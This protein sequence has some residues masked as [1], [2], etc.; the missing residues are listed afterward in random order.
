MRQHPGSY[1]IFLPP[2]HFPLHFHCPDLFHA[3]ATVHCCVCHG[4][5]YHFRKAR[6]VY[7]QTPNRIEFELQTRVLAD[8]TGTTRLRITVSPRRVMTRVVP[9]CGV[10]HPKNR[11]AD[12]RE[13]VTITGIRFMTS[14]PP[15]LRWNC[16]LRDLRTR[17]RRSDSPSGYGAATSC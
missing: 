14:R 8:T 11:V 4:N 3:A 12:R 13:A 1:Q 15:R 10:R 9:V 17:N 2:A 6:E 7:Q 5:I 16:N